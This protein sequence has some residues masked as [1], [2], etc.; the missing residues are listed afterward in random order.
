MVNI[1][2][3][4]TKSLP[5]IIYL[6]RY[7]RI[8]LPPKENSLSKKQ[9]MLLGKGR[10]IPLYFLRILHTAPEQFSTAPP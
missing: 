4:P 5:D 3:F 2:K 1:T 8:V 9:R 10:M 7:Q 6:T